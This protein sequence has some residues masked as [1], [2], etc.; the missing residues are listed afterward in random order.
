MVF[1]AHCVFFIPGGEAAHPTLYSILY[2][3]FIGVSFFFILSGFILAYRYSESLSAERIEVKT[4]WLRRWTRIYPPYLFCL[5]LSAGLHF[6]YL[7]QEPGNWLRDLGLHVTMLQTIVAGGRHA[8][9][10]NGPA[11]SV[12]DE[13]FFYLLFPLLIRI[14]GRSWIWLPALAIAVML[15]IVAMARTS[16][17]PAS[18]VFYSNPLIRLVDFAMGIALFQLWQRDRNR[19]WSRLRGTILE[20]AAVAVMVGFLLM[21]YNVPL[22]WRYSVFYWLPTLLLIYVFAKGAGVISTVLSKKLPVILGDASYS[23]YL[24]HTPAA[25]LVSS[26][27]RH[28]GM[29]PGPVGFITVYFLVSLGGSLLLFY[30]LERPVTR[31]LQRRLIHPRQ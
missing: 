9:T 20:L 27:F 3:G 4:F 25:I 29:Q 30:A 6:Q 18:Y 13:M 8:F 10:F 28:L 16:G 31:L 22:F 7:Q 17:P 5:L 2:E 1:F 19:T 15:V 26:G 23:L 14:A 24:F 21:R 12:A 11:W